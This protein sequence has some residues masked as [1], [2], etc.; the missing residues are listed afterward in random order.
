MNEYQ[1]P[2]DALAEWGIPAQPIQAM[3][4]QAALGLR[5]VEKALE[6]MPGLAAHGNEIAQAAGTVPGLSAL[7]M[8]NPSI[9]LRA[10]AEIVRQQ[11]SPPPVDPNAMPV[12]DEEAARSADRLTSKRAIEDFAHRRIS[13]VLAR[14]GMATQANPY[15]W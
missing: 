12:L 1:S 7:I 8:S 9:G 4:A 14:Q 15:G 13:G 10:A 11:N 2:E 6:A 5:N 3:V